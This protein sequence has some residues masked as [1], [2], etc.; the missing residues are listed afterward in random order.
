MAMSGIGERDSVESS[1]RMRRECRDGGSEGDCLV[2]TRTL[3][4]KDLTMPPEG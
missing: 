4:R 1:D 3:I 2:H